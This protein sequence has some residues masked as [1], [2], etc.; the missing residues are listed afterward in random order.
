ME[1]IDLEPVEKPSQYSSKGRGAAKLKRLTKI[2]S[3]EERIRVLYNDLGQPISTSKKELS[4]Y[5][6]LMVKCFVP[7]TYPS[8]PKVPIKLKNDLWEAIQVYIYIAVI[9]RKYCLMHFC[10]IHG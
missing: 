6:G 10:C 3:S 2:K 5:G 7:I 8:W 1:D 9:Y 4:S